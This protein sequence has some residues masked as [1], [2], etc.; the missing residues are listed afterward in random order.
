[1]VTLVEAGGGGGLNDNSGDQ[2]VDLALL[3]KVTLEVRSGNGR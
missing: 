2:L 3:V 1:M